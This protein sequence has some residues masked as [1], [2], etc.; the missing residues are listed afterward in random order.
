MEEHD[1]FDQLLDRAI[2][3]FGKAD[4]D[5]EECVIANV[6]SRARSSTST[7]YIGGVI[8][9]SVILG[10]FLMHPAIRGAGDAHYVPKPTASFE[11]PPGYSSS[12]TGSSGEPASTLLLTRSTLLPARLKLHPQ[13]STMMRS[14]HYRELPYVPE[15]AQEREVQRALRNPAFLASL[16][17]AQ[18]HPQP[19]KQ[20]APTEIEQT[21]DVE[22]RN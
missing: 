4:S 11:A 19:W 18:L 22:E 13:G 15:D 6:R 9:A 17:A 2:E 21:V 14:T 1:E 16:D 8:A 3:S 12:S 20:E 5:L 10:A 7:M